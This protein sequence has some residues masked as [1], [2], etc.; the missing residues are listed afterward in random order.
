SLRSRGIFPAAP[1]TSLSAAAYFREK[2]NFDDVPDKPPGLSALIPFLSVPPVCSQFSKGVYAIFG[3]YERR[4]VNMLTSFCGALHVCFITPSFPVETSNQFVLQLRPELQDALISVIEHYSWQKFVYIYDA[5]RG[6]SVLQK[7]LDTA[8]EKNW[9][10]T[11]VNILTTTEEGY[12]VLFQELQKKKERLVVVDCESERLNIILSKVMSAW[13]SWEGPACGMG[14][15]VSLRY[16]SAL[17]YDGVRVMAEAFQNL[18]RQRI[19]I[20]RR[21]NAGDCLANPAVPW[22][23]GI[24]IQRALQQVRFEGLSGNVQFNEKG[25]RTNYTLHVIEMKH[26]GIRKIGYWNEDEKLVPVAIDTQTGNE[27]T[28]LQNRTYIVTTILVIP[29]GT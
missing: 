2:V 16:T 5:D 22:G 28:S 12:R 6:L 23:Q 13:V 7:V 17:T 15:V 20:S 19:D 8:A 3:F 25:R 9:Q 24:D 29:F 4:T 10:V 1:S 27:S 21:G 14:R 11:A 26:D 18:R